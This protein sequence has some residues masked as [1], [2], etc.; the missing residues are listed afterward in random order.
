[1]RLISSSENLHIMQSCPDKDLAFVTYLLYTNNTLLDPVITTDTSDQRHLR[2]PACAGSF[3]YCMDTDIRESVMEF[4][5]ILCQYSSNSPTSIFASSMR[6]KLLQ[7]NPDLPKILTKI[8]IAFKYQASSFESIG[9]NKALQLIQAISE[10]SENHV[11]ILPSQNEL[12]ISSLLSDNVAE[13]VFGC[14][15]KSIF[16]SFLPLE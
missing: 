6:I 1:M 8:A 14:H 16:N 7:S 4:L 9:G 11:H 12:V 5:L 10:P 3:S 15:L 2:A 13:G